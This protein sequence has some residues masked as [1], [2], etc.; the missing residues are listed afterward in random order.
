MTDNEMSFVDLRTLDDVD[1]F[2][3]P[4]REHWM[5]VDPERDDN[6]TVGDLVDAIRNYR[7]S[8]GGLH[9]LRNADGNIRLV[10]DGSFRNT[11]YQQ[12]DDIVELYADGTFDVVVKVDAS[13][14]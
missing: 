12:C 3:D 8:H 13:E 5:K 7:T 4:D 9:I 10:D 2:I 14:H 6:L 11:D 1:L